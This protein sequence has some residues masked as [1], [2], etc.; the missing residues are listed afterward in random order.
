MCVFDTS[1]SNAY[2]AFFYSVCRPTLL[3]GLFV[4]FIM[5]EINVID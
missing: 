4:F 2:N 3:F 1:R 5:F